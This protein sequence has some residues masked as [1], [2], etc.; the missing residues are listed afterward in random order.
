M[1]NLNCKFLLL[2]SVS[3]LLFSCS[4]HNRRGHDKQGEG[5]A[6]GALTGAGA[7]A[8]TGIHLGAGAGPGV[9]VGAGIGAVAG[10]IKGLI[11][12]WAEEDLADLRARINEEEGVAY[13]HKMLSTHYKQR[14]AL[15]PA[16]DIYPAD[17]FFD[18]DEVNLKPQAIPLVREIARLNKRRF[19]WS[20][21]IVAVYVKAVDDD[22]EYARHL[23]I[24][25]S[26]E[27]GNN[28]VR[29][30]IEPRR[31]ESRGVLI[32]QPILIDPEDDPRR[33]SQAVEFIPVDK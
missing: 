14:I 30:G 3:L 29:F 4:P 28:L 16:R 5:L 12:D 26:R 25:R 21:F 10:S 17:W 6:M 27:I 31:I 11:Q 2:I 20:R 33:Y 32:E 23:A 22:S 24:E 7:G 13:A 1:K 19:P 8:V 9:A 15:H 18:G